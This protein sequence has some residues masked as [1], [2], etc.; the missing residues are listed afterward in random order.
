MNYDSI[1]CT[2]YNDNCPTEC[3]RALITKKIKNTDDP[4]FITRWASFIESESC[5]RKWI[6][7]VIKSIKIHV[8][9]PFI[10]SDVYYERKPWPKF[11]AVSS[12]ICECW[13]WYRDEVILEKASDEDVIL[14][15]KEMND[16]DERISQDRNNL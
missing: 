1:Y 6:L 3:H 10:A 15:L 14:A 4:P 13:C 5:P 8:A 9:P 2:D 12:G 11:G 16:Y 7:P